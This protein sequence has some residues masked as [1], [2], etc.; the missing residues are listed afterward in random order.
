MTTKLPFYLCSRARLSDT[1]IEGKI[2]ESV[3]VLPD[4][5]TNECNI[6]YNKKYGGSCGDYTEN[7]LK[8]QK[9]ISLLMDEK[10]DLTHENEKLKTLVE[11]NKKLYE[12][13]LKNKNLQIEIY[14]LKM[15]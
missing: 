1:I 4:K 2:S 5:K 7:T 15:S 6:E 11:T 8:L 10:K 13:E 3:C 9:Q 14:K 12:S